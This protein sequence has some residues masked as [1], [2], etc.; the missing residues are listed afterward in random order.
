[1]DPTLYQ[2]KMATPKEA[3][4]ISELIHQGVDMLEDKSYTSAQL[5]VWKKINTPEAIEESLQQRRI[6]CAF[7]GNE[8]IG[9][10]GLEGNEL[11]GL[12]I[13]PSRKKQ[14][15]GGM[16]L[17]HVE[18]YAAAHQM[19]ELKLTAIPSAKIYYQHKGFEVFQEVLT[20]VDGVEFPETEMVK[21]LMTTQ[22]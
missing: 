20:V 11:V 8:L 15:I 4:I 19:T 18:Q 16:L 22:S 3:A 5:A 1:M 12:Y 6:F 14:G 9:T 10:V 13:K 2:I 17:A 7:E 21:R